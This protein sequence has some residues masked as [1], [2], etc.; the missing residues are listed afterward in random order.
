MPGKGPRKQPKKGV[1]VP[2]MAFKYFPYPVSNVAQN[3]RNNRSE[4]KRERGRER[5]VFVINK[6]TSTCFPSKAK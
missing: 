1:R 3:G 4:R 5:E 2:E 6:E